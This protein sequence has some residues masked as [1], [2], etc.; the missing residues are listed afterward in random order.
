MVLH[1]LKIWSQFKKHYR[2]FSKSVYAPIAA[3]HLFPASL[4]DK[5]FDQWSKAGISN[6]SLHNEGTLMSFDQIKNKFNL[7][8]HSFF[9]YL[10]IR[11]F[12]KSQYLHYPSLPPKTSLDLIL[13][14]KPEVKGTIS[15]LYTF[16]FGLEDSSLESLK[17]KWEN[18]FECSISEDKWSKILKNIHSSSMCKACSYSI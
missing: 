16:I 15:K 11:D 14:I 6:I 12:I 8:S 1:S 5:A 2:L 18:D 9:R 3:N 4:I 10:Q 13:E 17:K 7:P